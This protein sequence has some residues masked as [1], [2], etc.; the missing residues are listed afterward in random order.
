MFTVLLYWCNKIYKDLFKKNVHHQV[1]L[2]HTTI[3]FVLIVI[4]ILDT[5]QS[6]RVIKYMHQIISVCGKA[7]P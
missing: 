3:T 7:P 1:V 2:Y 4:S 5:S 6:D